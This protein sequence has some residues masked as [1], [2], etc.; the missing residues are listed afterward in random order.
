M[1][2][3]Y[4]AKAETATRLIT[5][6][7]RSATLKSKSVSGDDWCPDLDNSDISV[8]VVDLKIKERDLPESLRGVVTRKLLVEAKDGV[9]IAKKDKI[10]IGSTTHEI[11]HAEKLAPAGTVVMW[12]AYLVA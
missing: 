11:E 7:G 10:T 3:D 6:F 1:S 5:R 12:T 4:A 8:R 2:F 9:T